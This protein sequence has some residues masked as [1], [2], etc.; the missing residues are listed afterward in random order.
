MLDPAIIG[1]NPAAQNNY[2]IEAAF[3]NVHF[4]MALYLA[5]I[6]AV[7]LTMTSNI[8]NEVERIRKIF[9]AEYMLRLN[10]L[11]KN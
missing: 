11:T 7:Q 2:A 3:E 8:E 1:A 9:K 4:K 5:S 6:P 10:Q